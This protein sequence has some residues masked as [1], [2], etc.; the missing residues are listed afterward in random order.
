MIEIRPIWRSFFFLEKI[1]VGP[2]FDIKV[3]NKFTFFFL[4]NNKK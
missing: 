1:F 2:T 4:K 3:I